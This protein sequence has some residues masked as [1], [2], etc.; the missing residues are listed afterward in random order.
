M[1]EVTH[2]KVD[3][4]M[5]AL[6]R[7]ETGVN[8]QQRIVEELRRRGEPTALAEKF[9]QRLHDTLEV[10]RLRTGSEASLYEG[11]RMLETDQ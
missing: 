2:L 6:E 10:R 8:Q 3:G 4:W 5:F 7:L 1:G 11:S 9:L